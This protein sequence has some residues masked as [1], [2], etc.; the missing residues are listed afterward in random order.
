M[1]VAHKW[2]LAVVDSTAWIP[3]ADPI[4]DHRSTHLDQIFITVI[5]KFHAQ[6]ACMIPSRLSSAGHSKVLSIDSTMPLLS[7]VNCTVWD[8]E[9]GTI[10]KMPVEEWI[11]DK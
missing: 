6:V 5:D 4:G 2:L 9:Q 1:V 7:L 3:H 10:I 8:L 11:H